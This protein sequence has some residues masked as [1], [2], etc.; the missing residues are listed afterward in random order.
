[1]YW[2][3]HLIELITVQ[4]LFNML[5]K[6]QSWQ[7]ELI[8]PLLCHY[9]SVIEI[10]WKKYSKFLSASK[11]LWAQMLCSAEMHILK[12]VMFCWSRSNF[13]DAKTKS[14]PLDWNKFILISWGREANAATVSV[15]EHVRL[16]GNS[17]EIRI[18]GQL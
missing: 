1:M 18:L 17:D 6:F 4:R 7:N 5:I 8:L 3:L 9:K 16:S 13:V 2:A 10:D 14:H 12:Q 11:K 15:C